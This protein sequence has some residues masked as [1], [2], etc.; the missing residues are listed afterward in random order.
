MSDELRDAPMVREKVFTVGVIFQQGGEFDDE[1]A[2]RYY[3]KADDQ[4]IELNDLVTVLT[5]Y[6]FSVVKVKEIHSTKHKNASKWIIQKLDLQTYEA[7]LKKDM[8]ITELKSDLQNRIETNRQK[9]AFE[10]LVQDD[11]EARKLADRIKELGGIPW[12]EDED[13]ES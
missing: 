11:E 12:E 7:K 4:A 10:S 2:T 13:Y 3:Y 1:D 8:Q 9:K 6:G 5:P